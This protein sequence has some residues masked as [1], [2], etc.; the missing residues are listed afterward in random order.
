MWGWRTIGAWR[1]NLQ[2]WLKIDHQN[3]HIL[4]LF[5]K[6]EGSQISMRLNPCVFMFSGCSNIHLPL[7]FCPTTGHLQVESFQ[8]NE[9]MF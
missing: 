2:V 3:F 4:F 6:K 8:D 1:E 9:F 5:E 7:R